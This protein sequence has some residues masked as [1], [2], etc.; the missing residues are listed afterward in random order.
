MRVPFE[1]KLRNC[2]EIN[3]I[4]QT[5]SQVIVLINLL[6]LIINKIKNFKKTIVQSFFQQKPIALISRTLKQESCV[7][8]GK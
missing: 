5:S 2:F 8:A 4:E 7:T 3:L 1:S 6:L